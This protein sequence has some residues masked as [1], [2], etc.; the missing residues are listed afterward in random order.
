MIESVIKFSSAAE[1]NWPLSQ[2]AGTEIV[3]ADSQTRHP[4]M[5]DRLVSQTPSAAEVEESA[6]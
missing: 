3:G 1:V 4:P 6:V 2:K 5:F